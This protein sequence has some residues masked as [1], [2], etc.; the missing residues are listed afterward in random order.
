MAADAGL[1]MDVLA[2]DVD[3]REFDPIARLGGA[4]VLAGS[5]ALAKAESVRVRL[6]NLAAGHE[7]GAAGTGGQAD[8]GAVI[9]AADQVG[10]RRTDGGT[11][12]LLSKPASAEDARS[13]LVAHSNA[14]VVL[15]N[16]LVAMDA[17]S[18]RWAGCFD[19]HYIAM[20]EI[21]PDRAAEYVEQCAPL[22]CVG[23]YRIEDGQRFPQWNFVTGMRGE[24]GL[25]GIMGLPIEP[26]RNLL[27]MLSV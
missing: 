26:L 23:A 15:T 2:P 11:T 8:G 18:G 19:I 7:F 21:S 12:T 3:E 9:V 10:E 27:A 20:G 5:L 22:D 1:V 25:D 24:S 13:M 17:R 14:T 4:R 6:D 16:G